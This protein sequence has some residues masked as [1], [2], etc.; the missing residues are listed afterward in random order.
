[1]MIGKKLARAKG[2]NVLVEFAVLAPVFFMLIM[3][4]VEFVLFQYKTYALNHVVAEAVRNL[5]TGEIKAAGNTTQ[6]FMD[7]MCAHSGLMIDCKAI[8]YDVRHYEKL[9]DIKYTEPTF[10]DEG[11][12]INFKFDPGAAGDYSVVRAST[13]HSFITPF[14]N[15]LMGTNDKKAIVNSFSIVRNEPWN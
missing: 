11:R 2:G 12:A 7:E 10:N 9:K 5:Q 8:D 4:I 15:E 14:M 13:P 3:G 1:M 6:A